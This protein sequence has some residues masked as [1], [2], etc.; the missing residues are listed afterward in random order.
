MGRLRDRMRDDL[1]L[2]NYSERTI[3][4]YLLYARRFVAHFMKPPEQITRDEVRAHLLRLMNERGLA[5][6]TSCAAV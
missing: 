2:R 4:G 6:S 3:Y 1:R 5:A